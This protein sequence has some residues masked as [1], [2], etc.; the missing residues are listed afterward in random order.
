MKKVFALAVLLA[1]MSSAWAPQLQASATGSPEDAIRNFI[2]QNIGLTSRPF[3]LAQLRLRLHATTKSTRQV[4]NPNVPGQTDRIV[5]LDDGKGVEVEA[6]VP[7]SG[8][9]LIQRITVTSADRTLPAKLQIGHSSLDDVYKSL[10][11]G[12]EDGK[13]PGG[14]SA[15]RYS[16]VEQTASALFWFDHERLA[17]VEWTFN[18]D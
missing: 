2:E 12:A 5:V 18:G 7:A 1:L 9:L 17:G 3:T 4:Q 8:P 15:K 14:V 10:G 6:Y 13:G 16:N 11:A